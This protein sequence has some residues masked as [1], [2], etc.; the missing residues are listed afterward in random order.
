MFASMDSTPPPLATDEA[1]SA[2]MVA[3]EPPVAALP[4]ATA[5]APPAGAAPSG[6]V[7]SFAK[8]MYGVGPMKVLSSIQAPPPRSRYPRFASQARTD[9]LA[10]ATWNRI[11]EMP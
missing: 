8:A 7:R 1:F 10:T 5:A 6:T 4:A 9:G 2:T 3:A 11:G